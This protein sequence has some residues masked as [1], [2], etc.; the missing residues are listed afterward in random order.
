M[1]IHTSMLSLTRYRWRVYEGDR[2]LAEG[3][4]HKGGRAIE[5]AHDWIVTNGMEARM[6]QME[7]ANG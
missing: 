1:R 3:I 6:E 4:V 7:E 5:A 2:L